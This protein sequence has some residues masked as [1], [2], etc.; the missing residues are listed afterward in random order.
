MFALPTLFRKFYLVLMPTPNPIPSTLM[1]VLSLG[2]YCHL[3]LCCSDLLQCRACHVSILS[4]VG[5]TCLVQLCQVLFDCQMLMSRTFVMFCFVK[6]KTYAMLYFIIDQEFI[7]SRCDMTCEL[8]KK[9]LSI[10][11]LIPI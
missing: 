10:H 8:E 5:C 9:I 3:T 1:L 2:F 6:W 11:N 7:D 4:V